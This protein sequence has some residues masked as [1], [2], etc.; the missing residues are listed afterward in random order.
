MT[1][2]GDIT[3]TL[4]GARGVDARIGA[5]VVRTDLFLASAV[6]KGAQ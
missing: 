6:A 1:M 3:I 5:H 4:A 2:T